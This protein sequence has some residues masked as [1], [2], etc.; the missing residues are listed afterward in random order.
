MYKMILIV[1]QK[2]MKLP[3]PIALTCFTILA[4]SGNALR[5]IAPQ[6][7]TQ[8]ANNTFG[9]WCCTK[10]SLT[11]KPR[12]TVEVMLKEAGTTDCNDVKFLPK[13]DRAGSPIL[14]Q[15]KVVGSSCYNFV[16]L[17]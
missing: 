17:R 13:S 12:H 6:T 10:A 9:D 4:L 14:V 11:P 5:A 8:P 3:R 1:E 7:P 2:Y 15:V 16:P